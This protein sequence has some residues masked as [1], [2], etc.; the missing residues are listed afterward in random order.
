M[1]YDAVYNEPFVTPTRGLYPE[2]VI[3]VEEFKDR[4][5]K[6]MKNR[7][8]DTGHGLK[9]GRIYELYSPDMDGEIV[10]ESLQEWLCDHRHEITQSIGLALRNHEMSYSE[11]YRYINDQ[12][13]PDELALYSLSRKHGIHTSVFNKGYVWTTLMNHLNRSD[14]EI[15]SLSGINLVYLGATMYGIIRDIRTP[16]PQQQSN[17]T[18][19]KTPGHSSKRANKVTCRSDSRG[20]KRGAKGSTDYGHC[21]RGKTS[22]TLSKS[23]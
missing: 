8:I 18:P 1:K 5:A 9:G 23:R 22:Q 16:H 14:E 2:Y 3:S 11:W 21:K 6:I 15:I 20:R 4:N 10:K 7:W 17:P 19:P 13:G 12:S